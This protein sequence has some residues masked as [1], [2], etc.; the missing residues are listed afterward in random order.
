MPLAYALIHE[1]D[2]NYGISFPDFPSCISGGATPEDAIRKGSE[3][4]SFHVSGMVEDGDPLPSVLRSINELKADPEFAEASEGA[5]VA[6]VPFDLP[7]KVV[8]INV[9][10][11]EGLLGSIDA[12]AKAV[13]QTRSAFL[14]DA[15]RAKIRAA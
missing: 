10:I 14:A 1:A 6:L 15:A 2:G 3:A 12:A 8:R 4:L 5:V 9:S 13:G 11:E 7:T